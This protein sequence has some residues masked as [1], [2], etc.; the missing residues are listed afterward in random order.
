MINEL[1][2][3]LLLIVTFLFQIAAY[4]L[5]GKKGLYAWIAMA[6]IIANIQVM[7]TIGIFGLVTAMGNIIY[8]TTFLACD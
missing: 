2:W 4:R 8:S 3:V 1:L 5:F 7:K 6:V